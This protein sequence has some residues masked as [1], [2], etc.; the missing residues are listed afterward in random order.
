[1]ASRVMSPAMRRVL[2]HLRDCGT[3]ENAYADIQV[4]RLS[5]YFLVRC[6]DRS[7][8]ACIRRGWVKKTDDECDYALTTAG[9]IALQF[10]K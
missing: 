7:L 9:V 10:F 5:G 4:P 1:M 8:D 3:F 6:I 2:E